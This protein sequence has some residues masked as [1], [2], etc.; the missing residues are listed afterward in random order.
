MASLKQQ[1]AEM[2]D[3]I[4]R[5]EGIIQTLETQ[6]KRSWSGLGNRLTGEDWQ[7]RPI[8]PSRNARGGLNHLLL[9]CEEEDNVLAFIKE[10]V[11]WREK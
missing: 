5:L 10:Y 9:I 2:E 1:K 3:E 8:K 7:P 4:A 11:H 6:A